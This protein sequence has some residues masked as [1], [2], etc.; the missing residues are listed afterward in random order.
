VPLEEER[1]QELMQ[2]T[3]DAISD[4]SDEETQQL[5]AVRN[6]SSSLLQSHSISKD[7]TRSME[8]SVTSAQLVA[9]EQKKIEEAFI[10]KKKQQLLSQ[11]M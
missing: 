5:R 6:K 10:A 11:F 4:S 1:E 2:G 3:S 9:A 8:E 7:E